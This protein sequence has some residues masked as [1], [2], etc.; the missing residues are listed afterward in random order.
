[1][2]SDTTPAVPKAPTSPLSLWERFKMDFVERFLTFET[3]KG[4][5]LAPAGLLVI[6]IA[7]FFQQYTIEVVGV[8][9]GWYM[10]SE[11]LRKISVNRIKQGKI[12]DAL[13]AKRDALDAVTAPQVEVQPTVAAADIQPTTTSNVVQQASSTIPQ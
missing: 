6:A 7:V 8:I 9:F 13:R 1:M 4:V 11:G 10:F 5:Y 2:A 3:A 12:Q